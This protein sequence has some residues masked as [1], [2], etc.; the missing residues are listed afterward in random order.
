M[1]VAKAPDGSYVEFAEG[2][3]IDAMRAYVNKHHPNPETLLPPAT[4]PEVKSGLLDEFQKGAR[5]MGNMLAADAT[6]PYEMFTGDTLP[7]MYYNRQAQRRD[8]SMAEDLQGKGA[9]NTYKEDG[10]NAALAYGLNPR[11]MAAFAGEQAP[12]WAGMAIAGAATGGAAPASWATTQVGPK[13]LG[14][15]AKRV[16]MGATAGA[17]AGGVEG[18]QTTQTVI[19][20]NGGKLR[21][22]AAGGAMTLA[23][24]ITNTVGFGPLISKLPATGRAALG[25]LVVKALAGTVV[26]PLTEWG[27]EPAEYA[28][29]RA[30]GYDASHGNPEIKDRTIALLD[31]VGPLAAMGLVSGLGGA[32]FDMHVKDKRAVV[33]TDPA[34]TWR[35]D[36]K[37]LSKVKG[38]PMTEE[39]YSALAY[40]GVEV[41][42]NGLGE[43]EERPKLATLGKFMARMRVRKGVVAREDLPLIYATFKEMYKGKASLR[44]PNIKGT[45]FSPETEAEMFLHDQGIAFETDDGLTMFTPEERASYRDAFMNIQGA[46]ED[47]ADFLTSFMEALMIH[48]GINVGVNPRLMMDTTFGG[49]MLGTEE[50]ETDTGVTFPEYTGR[51][52]GGFQPSGIEMDGTPSP[53]GLIRVFESS[54]F[55]TA[56]HEFAHWASWNSEGLMREAI[57]NAAGVKKKGAL[58][59]IAGWNRDQHDS[60]ASGFER[61]L[62]TKMAD[63]PAQAKVF[64]K[65]KTEFQKVYGTLRDAVLPSL[66]KKMVPVYDLM[67]HGSDINTAQQ[68][69]IDVMEGRGSDVELGQPKKEKNPIIDLAVVMGKRNVYKVTRADGSVREEKGGKEID[70]FM[71]EDERPAVPA[72]TAKIARQVRAKTMAE[73]EK[74]AALPSKA[75][76]KVKAKAKVKKVSGP[77]T[78]IDYE[79]RN[80]ETVGD[81]KRRFE[82]QTR[83]EALTLAAE[84]NKRF[85]KKNLQ[86]ELKHKHAKGEVITNV[87]LQAALLSVHMRE[88]LDDMLTLENLTDKD[89]DHYRKYQ[90]DLGYILKDFA[91]QA[92]Q[93]LQVVKWWNALGELAMMREKVNELGQAE[94]EMV[95]ATDLT[96]LRSM[97]NTINAVKE[98]SHVRWIRWMFYNSLLSG[99][100]NFKN[101][102]GNTMN[103]AYEDVHSFGMALTDMFKVMAFGGQRQYFMAEPFL[104]LEAQLKSLVDGE[105]WRAVGGA[106]LGDLESRYETKLDDEMAHTT[107]LVQRQLNLKLGKVIGTTINL[108]LNGL[109][110]MDVFA[111][112]MAENS[113]TQAIDYKLL[114][115][116]ELYGDEGVVKF[117]D[118]FVAKELALSQKYST[119]KSEEDL[120]TSRLGKQM[121]KELK[122]SDKFGMARANAIARFSEHATFQDQA[123][124][125]LKGL[126]SARS[127]VPGLGRVIMPFLQTN[128]NIMRRGLEL[129][130]GI[131]LAIHAMGKTDYTLTEALTKQLEG[132]GITLGVMSM[133]NMDRL[134][135]DAPDDKEKRDAFYR[136]G[137]LPYSIKFG[138]TWISYQNLE[139]LGFPM[140]IMADLIG[141]WKAAH[142]EG[143]EQ[144]NMHLFSTMVTTAKNYIIDQSFVSGVGQVMGED[145]KFQNF[146]ARTS[147]SLV[148]FSA[149][150]RMMNEDWHAVTDKEVPVYDRDNVAGLF[151]NATPPGVMDLLVKKGVIEPPKQKIDA[152][153]TPITKP[154]GFW[155]MWLSQNIRT[156]V[157]DAVEKEMGMVGYYP[158]TPNPYFTYNK[159]NIPIPDDVYAE[160]AVEYGLA[161]KKAVETIISRPAYKSASKEKKVDMIRGAV[162]RARDPIT[163][164]MKIKVRRGLKK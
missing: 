31:Q 23:A 139:P 140:G 20:Q 95:L 19:D 161:T 16:L 66:N 11:R 59:D 68:E 24:G 54:D 49:F 147:T 123:G 90:Q 55:S 87:D 138:N 137:K 120:L 82:R 89:L 44:S 39:E 70:A 62:M 65:I 127:I 149:F 124:R 74:M 118:E 145:Y 107:Q 162:E 6:I 105:L 104:M 152:F 130:P 132:V 81:R 64:E 144:H 134:T 21:A 83:E 91:S 79:A 154:V 157:E 75:P 2:T 136:E 52:R 25:S 141:E 153:G 112:G 61:Y 18:A 14:L 35:D 47:N 88:H 7:R 32:A 119:S 56:I 9:W 108:S 110:A 84:R 164:R 101:T 22:L 96:D 85:G 36:L 34:R 63:T 150:W 28:V 93:N 37:N 51:D 160:Y 133:M 113:M 13:V 67:L 80:K 1:P 103:A 100:T 129:T 30:A 5:R 155:G 106:L 40:D 26:E 53:V 128:A 8:I 4:Q 135:G 29:L 102:V 92:G 58:V 69:L 142:E 122:S 3:S 163:N 42:E 97:Q 131:G 126:A 17:M 115:I 12:L 60:F 143:A 38:T 43:M 46:T 45:S 73:A 109:K 98:K 151:W 111:K 71:E 48:Q 94:R 86:A 15:T 148:P 33:V 72:D 57:V 78:L 50:A 77:D 156:G 121:K 125:G 117:K 116:H 76:A 146:I 99:Y 41:V 114:K 158:G 27:E 159:E 10:F